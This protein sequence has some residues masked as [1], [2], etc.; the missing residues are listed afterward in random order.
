MIAK[1]VKS[2]KINPDCEIIKMSQSGFLQVIELVY[3]KSVMGVD[4]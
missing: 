3:S 2:W 1:V 4:I